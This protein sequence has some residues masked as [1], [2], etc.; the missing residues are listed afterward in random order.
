MKRWIVVLLVLLA[1]VILLSPAIVGRLAENN[2]EQNIEW[3]E[4]DSP[5]VSIKTES[6]ERG[7]LTSEGR[8]RVVLD[9]GQFREVAASYAEATGNPEL[10]S[11]IIDTHLDHGPL[12][13]GSM[14]PGLAET[15]STFMID[16]GNGE[17]FEI[18]GALTSRVGLNGASHSRLLLEPGSF[19]HET[20]TFEWQGADMTV[21]TNPSTATI[22]V[23][24]EIKAWKVAASDMVADFS[25][26][27]ITADQYRSDFGFNVG[28]VEMNMGPISLVEDGA[29]LS[30][31]S[32]S[33]SA[34][35]SINDDRMDGHSVVVIDTVN[36]PTVGTIDIAMDMAMERV[37]A[38]SIA[39]IG[40][41]IQEA[42]SAPDP[43]AALANLYPDIQ[44]ETETL[45]HKGF[46]VRMDKFDVALAQGVVSTKFNLDVPESAA[47][48]DF[49]WSTV[50]LTMSASIDLRIPGTIFE[51]AAMMNDQA[52][53]LVAMGVLVPD[54]EDFV[55]DAEYAQGLINVNGVPLP[56]PI[57]G[58]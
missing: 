40:K 32:L 16:P 17:P 25:A 33:L 29:E 8:H 22:S 1:V 55:M 38:A 53:S 26:I 13:A 48:T 21:D 54:G 14:S 20:T 52:G 35:S 28:S 39:V 57:P 58:L 56:V 43:E 50:L 31:E 44:E 47:D 46:S 24:G 37:D 27:S 4:S 34:E 3:A 11:L 2:I 15:V 42:Q 30:I 36:I 12:P 49:S 51:M 23:D 9:G 18:P 19:D 7:W 10:P 41:A 6:F 45:F 5:G